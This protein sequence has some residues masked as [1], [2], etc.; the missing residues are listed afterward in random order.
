MVKVQIDMTGWIM[1]EH[2]VSDSKLTIIRQVEDYIDPK[3]GVAIA[4]WLCECSCDNHTKI[5]ARGS[6]LRNGGVKS[7]GCLKAEKAVQNGKTVKKYNEYN[8]SEKYGIGYTSNT[9]HE[10]F[11][12]LEDYDLI[13]EYCWRETPSGYIETTIHKDGTQN[14]IFLHNLLLGIVGIDHIN[15]KRY[16]N[17]RKNLRQANDSINATNR[18]LPSNNTSGFIGVSW[19]K[20]DNRWT[21]YIK[22]DGKRKH[23]GN[24]INKRDA[25]ITRLKAERKYFGKIT[26]QRHLFEE[27]GITTKNLE[28]EI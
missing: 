17:R 3:S 15:R 12:D 1:A 6:D 23:L 19:N 5:S 20:R 27:Y 26:S 9:N 13:K 16:D 22:K 18:G 4:M 24:F 10:F 2:G 7:C 11:F 28:E 14:N 25:I 8:I 21:A